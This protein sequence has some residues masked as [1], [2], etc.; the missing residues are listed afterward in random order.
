MIWALDN[1]LPYLLLLSPFHSLFWSSWPYCMNHLSSFGPSGAS[2]LIFIPLEYSCLW[3]SHYLIAS[4]CTQRSAPQRKPPYLKHHISP[5]YPVLLLF[6]V[7]ITI[8]SILY[9]CLYLFASGPHKFQ[10]GKNSVLFTTL[11]FPL[12]IEDVLWKY[13]YQMSLLQPVLYS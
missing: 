3:S 6:I 8:K 13:L 9:I 2:H 4:A 7:F 10:K 1:L 5:L 12:F 11:S